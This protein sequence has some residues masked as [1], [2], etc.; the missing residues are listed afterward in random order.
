MSRQPTEHEKALTNDLRKK[1]SDDIVN[2]ML[3]NAD[4]V[5]EASPNVALILAVMT[6]GAYAASATMGAIISE[7]MNKVAAEFRATGVDPSTMDPESFKDESDDMHELTLLMMILSWL[8]MKREVD[9]SPITEALRLYKVI[10][11]KE[12]PPSLLTLMAGR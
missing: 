1:L 3:R 5:R 8:S 11:G 10:R 9:K 6:G 12:P 4:L 7:K 2:T